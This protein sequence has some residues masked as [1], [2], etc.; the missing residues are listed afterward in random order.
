[1]AVFMLLIAYT[2]SEVLQTHSKR[3]LVSAHDFRN[4]KVLNSTKN[5]GLNLIFK[6]FYRNHVLK[7]LKKK[8]KY[9][10]L[11]KFYTTYE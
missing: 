10:F 8:L 9:L 11:N 2:C 6:L 3:T 4:D 7:L 1:M 5:Y